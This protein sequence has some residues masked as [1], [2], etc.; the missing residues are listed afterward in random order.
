M[1]L[2]Y[3]ITT[4]KW[5]PDSKRL[6]AATRV[7]PELVG[8]FSKSDQAAMRKEIKRRKDSKMTAQVTEHRQYRYWDHALTD[9]LAHRL[10][11]VN[12]ETKVL[13]DLTP[14][15]DR[16]FS[17]SGEAT[18]DVAPDGKQVAVAINS[19]EPPYRE[20]PNSDIY[21]ISTDG[22]GGMKNLTADNRA[23]D[24]GPRFS[25]DGKSIVFQRQVRSLPYSGEHQ[26][27]WRHD[28]ATGK[29]VPITQ[30]L[31]YSFDEYQFSSD[32]RSLWLLTEERGLL[33]VFRMNPDGTGFTKVH[34]EGTNTGLDTARDVAVLLN[35]TFNRP[36][37]LFAL[38]L[39]TGKA[40][41]LTHF[42][43]EALAQLDLGK[44][45]SHTFAG[46]EGREIQLWLVYPPAY[47]AG[48][49][50]PLVQLMHGGPHTMVRDAFSFRWNAHVLAS[51]GYFVA[52]VNRHGSP[53]SERS[54]PAAF[55]ENGGKSP[56]RTSCAEQ[57]TC[58]ERFPA[59]TATASLQRR[60]LRRLYGRLGAGTHGSLQVHRE[61]RR[62]E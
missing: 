44:V 26:R 13:A 12:V 40:R 23:T 41:Q 32:G 61:P 16:L 47:D 9:N 56:S 3:G 19:V 49:Q 34:G 14:K 37:E 5:M 43:D 7:I 59:S 31:D 11:V 29:N 17:S 50:Y 42:N 54:L 4:P 46:A 39:K 2:P 55:W 28:L 21:L 1:E 60:Q 15:W 30:E 45:E 53:A 8:K 52:W 6:V 62:R 33:P 27:L 24:D 51:P 20:R 35:E 58:W 25:P 18:F 48:K 38:D 10:L 57:T 22:S 36:P